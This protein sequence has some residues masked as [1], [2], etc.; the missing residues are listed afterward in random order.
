MPIIAPPT[1]GQRVR[2]LPVPTLSPTGVASTLSRGTQGLARGLAIAGA[3][4]EDVAAQQQRDA[5]AEQREA[6]RAAEEARK[7]LERITI[8][9]EA[10]EIRRERTARLSGEKGALR[11]S[12]RQAGAVADQTRADFETLLRRRQARLPTDELRD[13]FELLAIEETA[14]LDSALDRHVV[15]QNFVEAERTRTQAVDAALE[16]AVA[17]VASSGVQHLESGR[18]DDRFASRELLLADAAL[19]SHAEAYPQTLGMPA[20][21][22][23]D[24]QREVVATELH[25]RVIDEL[26]R[27]GD[28][29]EARS[30]LTRHRDAIDNGAI[31][32]IE[33][34]L[35]AVTEAADRQ[36]VVDLIFDE[37]FDADDAEIAVGGRSL[38]EMERDALDRVAQLED[39]DERRAARDGIVRRYADARRLIRDDRTEV[40]QM[41]TARLLDG[42]DLDELQRMPEWRRL[43]QPQRDALAQRAAAL[44]AGVP[45]TTNA[46]FYHQAKTLATDNPAAFDS[47]DFLAAQNA[48]LLDEDDARELLNL[49]LKQRAAARG[50]AQAAAEYKSIISRE[51]IIAAEFDRLSGDLRGDD[52]V[53]DERRGQFEIAM[54]EAMRL[55]QRA[56]NR[57]MTP[58]EIRTEAR[59]IGTERLTRLGR[60]TGDRLPFFDRVRD[61][62]APAFTI[63]SLDIFVPGLIEPPPGALDAVTLTGDE[64][65]EQSF[66]YTDLF[67]RAPSDEQLR[68][69]VAVQM[70]AGRWLPESATPRPVPR[71]NY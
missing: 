18:I 30:W 48:Q 71:Y 41:L 11:S 61:R 39:P 9:R 8:A 37:T 67:G 28:D 25:T 58:S 54:D 3:Q 10:A 60:F 31:P 29:I 34:A 32:R 46:A 53:E 14:A 50:D 7:R 56:N 22:W 36:A 6:D 17:R 5:E 66:V 43:E 21:E 16:A 70:R 69:F 47:L 27:R 38:A 63:E 33:A 55:F 1:T 51:E 26:I 13:A 24:V 49:Q 35:D 40:Q 2:P 44:A 42:R 68:E 15:E 65:T 52:D 20:D 4:L 64:W 59:A 57:P 12:G 62:S 19:R 45:A 23:L